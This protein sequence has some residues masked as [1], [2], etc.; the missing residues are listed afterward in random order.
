M[1][2]V[3]KVKEICKKRKIPISKLEK[4]LGFANGYVGQL[5]K[6][7]FPGD[8]LAAI[9]KYLLVSTEYLLG[10]EEEEFFPDE[11]SRK[12]CAQ[13]VTAFSK[14]E[15]LEKAFL[16]PDGIKKEIWSGTYKF[17]NVTYPQ[18]ESIVGRKKEAAA[19]KGDG[20]SPLEAQLMEYIR[21]LTDDQKKMLLAQI[22]LLLSKQ[23]SLPDSQE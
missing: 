19:P 3:E 17:S 16:L 11:E 21:R 14:D 6:G 1:T 7:T 23:E 8:R 5:K 15:S 18:F 9:S 4:D 12:I 13:I 20:L 22:E 10:E 2:S